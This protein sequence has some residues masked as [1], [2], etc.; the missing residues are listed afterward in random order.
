[1]QENQESLNDEEKLQAENEFIKMKLML[2]QSAK[3]GKID[4]DKKLPCQIE[5][6]FL[7]YIMAYEKQAA[8]PKYIKMY[9]RI[10]RPLHFKPVAEI[11]DADI[12]NAWQELL[13]YINCYAIT[14]TVCSPNISSR[15]L[16]RFTTEELFEYELNDINI[17][18]A[19]TMFTYDEF[20]P[21]PIYDNPRVVEED[22]FPDIFRIEPIYFDY[23]FDGSDIYL[24]DEIF[25]GYVEFKE[26]IN[27]F[28]SLFSTISLD[29]F[30][31][32]S[33]EVNGNTS[34]VKGLYHSTFL[35]KE[36]D[37][38]NTFEG[39]YNVEFILGD[40]GYWLIKKM[41]FEAI[42]F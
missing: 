11:S 37:L 1:M 39:E 26:K 22:L 16:Y 31:T 25:R 5:N 18:G 17:P 33:I 12:E 4:N 24:N 35:K 10:Q 8:N 2:E 14:L 41:Y 19:V 27:H 34:V 29:K 20:Y 23:G 7:N 21:D 13:A 28:K 36:D 42:S 38:I 15:E 32:T 6:E 3:F 40:L 30:N 9:D